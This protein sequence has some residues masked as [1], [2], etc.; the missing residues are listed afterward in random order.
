[1]KKKKNIKKVTKI[2]NL[3]SNNAQSLWCVSF[4]Y[5]T[6]G[7]ISAPVHMVVDVISLATVTA[8]ITSE[9]ISMTEE[10]KEIKDS[11]HKTV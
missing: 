11:A 6:L 2:T 5:K 8:G 10:S 7:I 9:M 1:M 4:V 3:L